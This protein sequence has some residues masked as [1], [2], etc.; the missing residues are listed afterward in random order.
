M[1]V[2]AMIDHTLLAPTAT[3][4]QIRTLCQEAAHWRFATVC[5]APRF[6][7]LC[8]HALVGTSVRVCTVLD[9]PLSAADGAAKA[10]LCERTIADGAQEV[11]MVLPFAPFFA[12]DLAATEREI[13]AVLTVTRSARV[14]SKVILETAL[15]TPAQIDAACRICCA[16]GA[17][18]VKTST[19]FLGPGA[20]VA[21][22]TQMRAA[23]GPQVG[24][25]ASGGIRDYATAQAMIAAGATRIGTSSG[26]AIAQGAP[27]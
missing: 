17:D 6:V 2:A 13:A 11:D 8:A 25:K 21:A 20:T 9:F 15:L 18:F 14:L 3:E 24:V 12:G 10:W 22:V 23:V 4:E 7:S 26:I 1:S 5:V 27:R 16:T 19:G